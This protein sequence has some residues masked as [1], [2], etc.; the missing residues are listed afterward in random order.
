MSSF[1]PEFLE[2]QPITVQLLSTCRAIGEFKGKQLLFAQQSPERLEQLRQVAVI[3]STE[4][5]NRIEGVIAP[6][7][8]IEALVPDGTNSHMIRIEIERGRN[9]NH[10]KT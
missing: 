2:R 10:A 1:L 3:Q 5:S 9:T 7:R 4:S 6:L 8:R